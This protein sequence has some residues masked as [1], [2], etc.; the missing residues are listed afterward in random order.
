M[1]LK[2]LKRLLGAVVLGLSLSAASPVL[3]QRDSLRPEVGKPLQDAQKLIQ[4]KQFK[5][6]LKPIDQAE[7]VGKLTDYEAFV[8]AQMRGAAYSGAGDAVKAATAFEQVL[9]ANRLP[10]EEALKI[11]EGV[12][13][14]FYRA[15]N[16]AQAVNWLNRYR[17]AGGGRVEV[18]E[19]IPQAHY[20]AGDYAAAARV[21][22][23]QVQATEAA[24]QRP[25]ED[26]LRLLASA[27]AQAAD[28]RGYAQALERLV[29]HY[30]KAE[31]WT[32][33]IQ[34]TAAQPGFSRKLDL[35]T[36]RLRLAA[37][38]MASATDYMEAA[39]LAMQE[40]LPGEALDFLQRGTAAKVLGVGAA[41]DVERQQRLRKLVESK[42]AEDRATIASTAA[43]AKAAGGDALFRTGLAYVTYGD[44]AKGLSMMEH[45][46]KQGPLQA[47]GHA[48]L[49]LG[50]AYFLAGDQARA[51]Q[52]F[53][54][55]R[56]DDGAAALAR[57][58]ILAVR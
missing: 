26:S 8:I 52:A 25:D 33:V 50:Y 29:R 5:Q 43:D 15:R 56:G 4:S 11:M 10:K 57:L 32:D 35:D 44:T 6:A 41:A 55:V 12:A 20:L 45:S 30:P 7:A 22:A 58:W 53:R 18:L 51:V 31:Y 9:D 3:A 2:S 23:E 21:A 46:A 27:Y 54:K 40:G 37:G 16:Y 47:P 49:R 13:G 17:Q 42:R 1:N 24:G 19:L 39:Q 28:M 34:R 38:T 14:S 48:R 36:Y